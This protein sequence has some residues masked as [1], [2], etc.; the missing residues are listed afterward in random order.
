MNCTSPR[1]PCH[2][3]RGASPNA[4]PHWAHTLRRLSR[5][6]EEQCSSHSHPTLRHGATIL[7]L[8]AILGA[9]W[10]CYKPCRPGGAPDWTGCS[11]GALVGSL[12][13]A[14]TSRLL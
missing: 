4:P 12:S 2:I 10:S 7:G 6:T 5:R 9:G 13:M 11:R 1:C 3:G 8:L 14:D